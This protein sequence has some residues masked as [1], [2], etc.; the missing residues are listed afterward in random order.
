MCVDTT[1]LLTADPS[2][3]NTLGFGVDAADIA[4]SFMHNDSVGIA[5]KDAIAGQPAL[6]SNNAYDAYIFCR[7]NDTTVL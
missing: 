6:S 1:A 5:T 3:F 4:I 7:P 2:K